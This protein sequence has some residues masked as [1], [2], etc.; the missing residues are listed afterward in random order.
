MAFP[1]K[2]RPPCA[3]SSYLQQLDSSSAD[4]PRCRLCLVVCLTLQSLTPPSRTST[5]GRCSIIGFCSMMCV[6]PNPSYATRTRCLAN[7]SRKFR[8]S[9]RIVFLRS[10]ILSRSYTT[11]P[12]SASSSTRPVPHRRCVTLLPTELVRSRRTE[13]TVSLTWHRIR[14]RRAATTKPRSWT[15]AAV[16]P[17]RSRLAAWAQLVVQPSIFLALRTPSLHRCRRPSRRRRL[18]RC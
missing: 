7:L 9:C 13:P 11:S 6:Q 18:R 12:P 1:M 14:A 17:M 16:G 5:I 2:F 15:R 4:L 10:L 3:S 8:R